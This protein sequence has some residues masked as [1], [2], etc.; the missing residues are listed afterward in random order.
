[1]NFYGFGIFDRQYKTSNSP[2]SHPK[3][4]LL[5]FLW[6]LNL[7]L[8]GDNWVLARRK[9]G[10]KEGDVVVVVVVVVVT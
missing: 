2:G 4:I 9:K 7:Y 1:L 3:I 8:T 6:F 5:E 10:R